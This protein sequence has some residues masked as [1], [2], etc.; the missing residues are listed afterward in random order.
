MAHG[1]ADQRWTLARIR[2]LIRRL[3][4]IDYTVPGVWYLMDRLGWSAQKPA[5]QAI[6]RDPTAVEVW[7][8]DVGPS[9]NRPRRPRAP[10]SSSK[11]NPGTT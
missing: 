9:A 2:D 4:D 7:K 3:F 6:E 8:K 1:W 10:G 5:R 11:A